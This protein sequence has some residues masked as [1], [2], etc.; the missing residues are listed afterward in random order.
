MVSKV[1]FWS[2]IV[3]AYFKR[4][5]TLNINLYFMQ[6]YV[7]FHAILSNDLML[8]LL[9]ALR[10]FRSYSTKPNQD[11][12]ELLLTLLF[13]F[14]PPGQKLKLK[15][16][17]MDGDFGYGWKKLSLIGGKKYGYFPL[18]H[19]KLYE[20]SEKWFQE[21]SCLLT[22]GS[23]PLILESFRT[24]CL[25]Q[26]LDSACW[27]VC[28]LAELHTRLCPHSTNRTLEVCWFGN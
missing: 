15:S 2:Q 28:L 8:S 14:P 4:I 7:L 16:H 10:A 23:A 5:L 3:F 24:L 13:T 22:E 26:I 12:S 20:K 19:V 1:R 18:T 21:T 11:K 9:Q 6:L 17:S 25:P 27:S